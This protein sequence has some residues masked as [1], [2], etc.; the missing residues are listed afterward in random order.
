LFCSSPDRHLLY[1]L[2]LKVMNSK[3]LAGMHEELKKPWWE[4]GRLF[5]RM[6]IA[7]DAQHEMGR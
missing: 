2:S 4:T 6:G 1:P 3:H 7:C 5:G